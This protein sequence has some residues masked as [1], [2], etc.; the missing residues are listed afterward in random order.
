MGVETV[1]AA[2][3]IG[4][5]AAAGSTGYSIYSGKK[6]EKEQKKAL[7][8]QN[9]AI[10][11]EKAAALETRKQMIDRQRMQLAGNGQGTRGTS[12][13]GIKATIGNQVLG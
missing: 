1:A 12:R 5:I 11:E 6:Q 8:E 13:S 10:A 2:S 3:I 9:A 7:R 4:A